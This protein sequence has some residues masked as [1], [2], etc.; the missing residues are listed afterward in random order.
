MDIPS[1]PLRAA[2]EAA[3]GCVHPGFSRAS[4]ATVGT[5]VTKGTNAGT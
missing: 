4:I 5:S 3:G 2:K 1:G